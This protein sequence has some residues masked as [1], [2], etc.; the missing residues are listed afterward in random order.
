MATGVCDFGARNVSV[1]VVSTGDTFEVR[2]TSTDERA[3]HEILIGAA[4]VI[5]AGLWV[6]LRR[7][8]RTGQR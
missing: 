7:P 3:A 2:L 4:V 6:A 5:G 1:S 8:R